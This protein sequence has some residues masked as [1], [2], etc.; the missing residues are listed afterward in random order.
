MA[1]T[2][3]KN[4]VKGH[5]LS[6]GKGR[7][8]GSKI[9]KDVKLMN[10]TICREKI[11]LY[12]D[13]PL[14]ELEQIYKDKTSNSLDLMIIKIIIMAIKDGD[15]KRLGFLFDRTIGKV[16]DKIDLGNSDGSLSTVS[17]DQMRKIA[18]RLLEKNAK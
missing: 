8:K 14:K 4:F 9:P 18:K 1:K 13:K 10:Q 7:P 15:Y 2:G 17:A 6:V 16:T 12:F 3:G 11:S 5:R